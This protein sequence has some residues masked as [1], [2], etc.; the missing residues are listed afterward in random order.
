M[1]L[2]L[3]VRADALGHPVWARSGRARGHISF[4]PTFQGCR[5]PPYLGRVGAAD[6][7]RT[8]MAYRVVADHMRTLS[9]CIADGVSLGMSGAP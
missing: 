7:G 2:A 1:W 6:E 9:V 5:A 4:S 3:G 8:D